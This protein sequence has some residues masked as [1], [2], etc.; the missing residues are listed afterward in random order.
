LKLNPA[1]VFFILTNLLSFLSFWIS[2]PVGLSFSAIAIIYLINKSNSFLTILFNQK[3]R[4]FLFLLILEIGS[5]IN[6]IILDYSRNVVY[7]NPELLIQGISYLLV[8][9]LLFYYLGFNQSLKNQDSWRKDFIVILFIFA[10]IFLYG[11]Y[12]HFWRPDYFNLFLER[13]FLN[14][15]QTGYTTI[16]PK[17][18]IFW[19]S[20]IVGVLGVA[21]FWLNLLIKNHIF[22]YRF[23]FSMIFLTAIVFSTQ[24][25]AWISLSISGLIVLFMTFRIRKILKYLFYLSVIGVVFFLISRFLVIQNNY[26]IYIDLLNRFDNIENAFA[27]RNNQF[28]NFLFLI[29]KYPF[30]IGLGLLSHKASDLGLSFTTPD[31]NY[32]RIIGEI[33]I[34][35]FISFFTLLIFS[36]YKAYKTRIIYLFVILIIYFL[37]AIG[38]NVF[39]LYAASFFFWYIIGFVNGYSSPSQ[40]P[41]LL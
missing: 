9:Q 29:S 2:Y 3:S 13:V 4:I 27:D 8:P 37:Q 11:I 38:T 20:M 7:E 17:Y 28:E 35:G 26:E 15:P 10:F 22:F 25:G 32:Y 16:Y 1:I 41:F 33:G 39:D 34:L 5:F 6:Y 24:R 30:G 31:G 12:L 40:K 19:N 18:T 21:L 23:F 36:L 14:D